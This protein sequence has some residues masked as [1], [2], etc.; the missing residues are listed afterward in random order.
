LAA[1]IG[2]AAVVYAA[3]LLVTRA[4]TVREM[5]ALVRREAV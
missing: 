4:V 1:L 2:G 3:G 5:V